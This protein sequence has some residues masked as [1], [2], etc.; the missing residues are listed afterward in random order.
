MRIKE[1]QG[2]AESLKSPDNLRPLPCLPNERLPLNVAK[3]MAAPTP[4][5]IKLP[6][7]CH[8]PFSI[9]LAQLLLISLYQSVWQQ[10]E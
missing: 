8:F 2:W 9:Q 5:G 3:K 4:L 1:L 7:L 10:G 6:N